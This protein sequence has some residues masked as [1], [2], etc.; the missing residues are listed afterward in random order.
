MFFSSRA[1]ALACARWKWITMHGVTVLELQ[2]LGGLREHQNSRYKGIIIKHHLKKTKIKLNVY[3]CG[4]NCVTLSK[5]LS[6]LWQIYRVFKKK[7]WYHVVCLYM[8]CVNWFE[9]LASSSWVV[10]SLWPWLQRGPVSKG[11]ADRTG[12]VAQRHAA[13]WKA[14][15]YFIYYDYFLFYNTYL[16][17]P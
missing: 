13:T 11:A 4:F 16:L 1:N 3:D 5:R 9:R 12:H 15:L 8:S 10:T 6:S 17:G 7:W 2:L 14:K